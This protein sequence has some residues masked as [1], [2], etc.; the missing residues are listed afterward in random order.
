MY[1]CPI[2][3]VVMPTFKLLWE[4]IATL[5][6]LRPMFPA[7]PCSFES[8][9]SHTF[10]FDHDES[11]KKVWSTLVM[12][13]KGG[14]LRARRSD[15]W[16]FHR[17]Y[18]NILFL[19]SENSRKRWRVIWVRHKCFAESVTFHRNSLL[20]GEKCFMSF[21]RYQKRIEHDRP[22]RESI[23]KYSTRGRTYRDQQIS[24]RRGEESCPLPRYRRI[25]IRNHSWSD[26]SPWV[27]M[28]SIFDALFRR[29]INM[30]C[31]SLIIWWE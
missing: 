12:Q 13:Q 2:N 1:L 24:I 10:V 31:S 15:R 4:N 14:W 27:T 11:K 29:I 8:M 6:I 23:W 30:E 17:N 9:K 20:I 3:R 19:S 5:E 7:A 26:L 25:K 28:A 16:L 22:E 18:I 21:V